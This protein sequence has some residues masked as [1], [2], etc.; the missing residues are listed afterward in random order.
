L[1][2]DFE[3]FFA[4]RETIGEARTVATTRMTYERFSKTAALKSLCDKIAG[5]STDN[6]YSGEGD[7]A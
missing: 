1:W 2:G 3:R 6:S 7:T 4:Q 5:T